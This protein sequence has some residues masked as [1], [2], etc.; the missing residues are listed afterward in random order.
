[1]KTL[2]KE[3]ED[4]CECCC[5]CDCCCECEEESCDGE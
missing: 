3:F 1:M 2:Y 5:E 4:C